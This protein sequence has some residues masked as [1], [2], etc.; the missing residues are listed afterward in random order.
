V[1]GGGGGRVGRLEG[2]MLG[3]HRR[4]LSHTAGATSGFLLG[5]GRLVL[6]FRQSPL[7]EVW[8]AC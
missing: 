5:I 6:Q 7:V 1:G 8:R 2:G 4:T 3:P